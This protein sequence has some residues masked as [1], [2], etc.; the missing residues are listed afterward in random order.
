MKIQYLYKYQ[1][2]NGILI[3]PYYQSEQ[4]IPHACRLIAEENA[5]ITNGIDIVTCIDI[6]LKSIE[7]W[8]DCDLPI[9]NI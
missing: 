9:E 4:D 5:G 1:L 7:Q 2:D 6:D 8:N 3:T